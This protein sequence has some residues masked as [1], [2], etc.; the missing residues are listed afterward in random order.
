[1]PAEHGYYGKFAINFLRYFPCS[2]RLWTADDETLTQSDR[3]I[4]FLYFL[5]I[6]RGRLKRLKFN[7]ENKKM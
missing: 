2:G 4:T 7:F 6:G 3:I 5:N 1:M